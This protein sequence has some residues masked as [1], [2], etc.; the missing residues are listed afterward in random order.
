MQSLLGILASILLAFCVN[1]QGI[2]FDFD[3]PG[4]LGGSKKLY[5]LVSTGTQY[6][7]CGVTASSNL[8]ID[9]TFS[10]TTMRPS[11]IFGAR[12][13][14][15]DAAFSAL[16][17]DTPP[18]Q[19]RTDYGNANTRF[20]SHA[21]STNT[22]YRLSKNRNVTTL[23]DSSGSVLVSDT[24]PLSSFGSLLYVFVFWCNGNVTTGSESIIKMSAV[25]IYRDSALVFSG[26]P[27]PAGDKQYSSNPAPSNCMFDNVS[28]TYFVNQG[29]GSFG[30][31]E[32]K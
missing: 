24:G 31:E 16:I 30:I 23:Y 28:K 20:L 15:N 11:F 32:V 13:A 5:A 10:I 27:V 19:I 8:F 18:Y 21:L 1:S 2:P 9:C 14:P 7:N 17:I 12:T 6:L 29:T 26:I 25:R 4:T 3:P 22:Y